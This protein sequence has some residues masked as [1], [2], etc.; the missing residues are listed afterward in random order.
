MVRRVLKYFGFENKTKTILKKEFWLNQLTY[1]ERASPFRIDVPT[2]TWTANFIITTP[3]F[4][5]LRIKTAFTGPVLEEFRTEKSNSLLKWASAFVYESHA[6]KDEIKNFFR[7]SMN[8]LINP[9]STRWSWFKWRLERCE[10]EESDL[11]VETFECL[12]RYFRR[13]NPSRKS[14]EQARPLMWHDYS[15]LN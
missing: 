15:V 8:N 4:T 1:L 6:N 12:F 14:E 9:F 5:R 10:T 13:E 2:Q 7:I 3:V 11:V